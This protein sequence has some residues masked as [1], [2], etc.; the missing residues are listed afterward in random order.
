MSTHQHQPPRQQTRG[1]LHT[2]LADS[3]PA[4]SFVPHLQPVTDSEALSA[5]Q[6]EVWRGQ[7]DVVVQGMQ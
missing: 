5:G 1:C 7:R 3:A 2:E 6:T 4:L